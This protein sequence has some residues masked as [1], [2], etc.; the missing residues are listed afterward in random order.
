MMKQ[1]N[2]DT[3]Y[4]KGDHPPQIKNTSNVM[5]LFIAHTQYIKYDDKIHQTHRIH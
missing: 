3:V 2:K 1:S 5:R 4:I